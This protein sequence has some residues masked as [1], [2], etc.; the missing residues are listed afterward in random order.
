MVMTMTNSLSRKIA[1]EIVDLAIKKWWIFGPSLCQRFFRPG[2]GLGS[3]GTC[4]VFT[5]K[6]MSLLISWWKYDWEEIWADS[7]RW[8]FDGFWSH[9]NAVL[10][11]WWNGVPWG[12]SWPTGEQSSRAENSASKPWKILK[13]HRKALVPPSLQCFVKFFAPGMQEFHGVPWLS[14]GMPSCILAPASSK[15]LDSMPTFSRRPSDAAP[16]M[17][18]PSLDLPSGYY[19]YD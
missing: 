11:I 7:W 8:D 17:V 2:K 18:G 5:M 14:S 4:G 3:C 12:T 16:A 15:T 1:I 10:R 13:N 19:G 6:V 9:R